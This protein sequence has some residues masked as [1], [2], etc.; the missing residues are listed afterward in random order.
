MTRSFDAFVFD[1]DGTL[2]DTLPDLAA[3]TN[4]VLE[5]LGHPL[6]SMEEI[7]SYVGNGGRRLIAE[8][9]PPGSTDEEIENAFQLWR[10][11]HAKHG[12]ELTREY[13]GT[14]GMLERLKANGKKIAVLS[15]K[16]DEGIQEVIPSLFPGVFSVYHGE[17]EV[18]PRKPDP[19]GLLMTLEELGV[20]PSRAAYVG[21]SHVDMVTARNA[22]CFALGVAWGYQTKEDLEEGGADVIVERVHDILKFC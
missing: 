2:L 5:E 15:N 3:V 11:T 10:E 18:I 16:F 13:V 21:D 7:L 8:A 22:G 9:M 20:E 19:T 6:H 12:S 4:K 14:T 1:C 17:S